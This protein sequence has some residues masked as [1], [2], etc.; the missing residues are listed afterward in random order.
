[1]RTLS[2]ITFKLLADAVRPRQL[3]RVADGG[4]AAVAASPGV[5]LM[6]SPAAPRL[7]RRRFGGGGLA[8]GVGEL[9]SP[10]SVPCQ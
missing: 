1:M 4:P 5:G 2:R 10:A 8:R 3:H 7:I 9:P 6:C